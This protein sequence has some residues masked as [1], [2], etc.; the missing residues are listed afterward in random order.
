MC[1]C[2]CEARYGADM[3][4]YGAICMEC[5]ERIWSK[6]GIGLARLKTARSHAEM[7]EWVGREGCVGLGEGIWGD[8]DVSKE[9]S[10]HLRSEV[11]ISVVRY[12]E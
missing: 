7:S 5:M 11:G 6:T 1:L 10:V 4:R 3:D 2:L 9:A 12:S 8:M